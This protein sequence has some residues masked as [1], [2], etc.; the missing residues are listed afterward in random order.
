M[1][2]ENQVLEKTNNQ[3]VKD[4]IVFDIKNLKTYF[5]I[6]EGFI[7]KKV[8][9]NVKAVDDVSFTIKEEKL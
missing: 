9:N 2:S 5:P 4:E 6:Y 1:K 7:K 8:V 3:R